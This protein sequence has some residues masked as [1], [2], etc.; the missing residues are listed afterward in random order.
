MLFERFV[1]VLYLLFM[2]A[3]FLLGTLYDTD[4]RFVPLFA[5]HSTLV[6]VIVVTL[7][8]LQRIVKHDVDSH[9]D[10]WS[11]VAWSAVHIF[12]P[13]LFMMDGLEWVNVM[14]VLA[15]AGFGLTMMIFVVGVCSCYVII[16][17]GRDWAPHIHL[18]CITFWV[19]VQYMSVRLP[20]DGLL[21]VTTVPSVAMAALRVYEN[22]EDG[23]DVW[24]VIEWVLWCCCILFHV[25]L[26][27]GVWS[28]RTFYWCLLTVIC[29]MTTMSRHVSKLVTLCVL[30]FALVPLG[31]YTCLR[32]AQGYRSV[33]IGGEI[34]KLYDVLT[35]AKPME[36]LEISEEED[37]FNARL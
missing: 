13:A 23:A 14:V 3:W 33:D 2:Y 37:D 34:S 17:N 26:D 35:A 7:F 29:I 20:M 6:S 18:T 4:W 1:F 27:T 31:L 36:P 8:Q 10:R 9:A 28:A 30:P 11:T 25:F 15:I 21:Y 22:V 32:Y 24:S 12:I 19:L 16:L 5:I